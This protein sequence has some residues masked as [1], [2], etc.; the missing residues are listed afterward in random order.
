MQQH[1]AVV[2][3]GIPSSDIGFRFARGWAGPDQTGD[4]FIDIGM[5]WIV[6]R[7]NHTGV[8][9]LYCC[10][11]ESPHLEAYL[12]FAGWGNAATVA[13][14]LEGALTVVVRRVEFDR[15]PD[16]EERVVLRWLP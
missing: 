4:A 9:T 6:R 16:G 8:K 13:K 10:Q 14:E 7:L 15:D 3:H 5:A 1:S 2:V 12:S 11:G